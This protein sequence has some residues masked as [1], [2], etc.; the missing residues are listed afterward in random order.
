LQSLE[1]GIIQSG[2][3]STFN[4]VVKA[5]VILTVLLLQS[6]VFRQYFSRA[7]TMVRGTA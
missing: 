2:L 5:I 3:P 1:T 6:A 7:F 4:L